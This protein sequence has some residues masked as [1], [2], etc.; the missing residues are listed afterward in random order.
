M[1][2]PCWVSPDAVS[3]EWPCCCPDCLH[4]LPYLVG[5]YLDF[6]TV[7]ST[8]NYICSLTHIEAQW[9]GVCHIPTSLAMIL[10]KLLAFAKKRVII[11]T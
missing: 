5:T 1:W 2:H 11:V 10:W 6:Q 3:I 7:L 8:Y 9:L 4:R